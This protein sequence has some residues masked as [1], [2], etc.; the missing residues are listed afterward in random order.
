M[1][2]VLLYIAQIMKMLLMINSLTGYYTI[3][4]QRMMLMY[5]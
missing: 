2:M 4:F 1:K 3:L 5:L